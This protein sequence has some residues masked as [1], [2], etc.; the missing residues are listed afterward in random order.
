LPAP[1]FT[2][3]KTLL[4]LFAALAAGFS[5]AR[6]DLTIVE[7]VEG[8]SHTSA[9]TV[10]IKGDKARIE[11]NPQ[12]TTIVDSKKG[13]ITSL[14]NDRKVFL[15]MSGDRLR[16][17]MDM[18][19]KFDEKSPPAAKPKLIPTGRKATINGYETE[20]YGY[21]TP[22]V[23]ASF[24]VAPSY[25]D[26][27]AILKQLAVLSSGPL[28]M[29]NAV[30]PDYA[31]IPGVPLKF[32]VTAG[33]K[34][35]T[36]TVSS[37]NQEPLSDSD[38]DVPSDYHEMKGP[39]LQLRPAG[40]TSPAGPTLEGSGTGVTRASAD[41]YST[42]GGGYSRSVADN[43]PPREFAATGRIKNDSIACLRP[44]YEPR[45]WRAMLRAARHRFS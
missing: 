23:K 27:A 13:E 18:V 22:K 29:Q 31:E 34:D 21:E 28:K 24:W 26:G 42:A 19:N 45:V 40:Q 7:N 30:A 4:S 11:A 43:A 39:Q 17:A 12:L 33:G 44:L 36:T 35:I 38:F 3:V 37:L 41:R 9:M 2:A 25:P 20:E 14:I 5:S 32:V 15:R 1:T 6:A 10:K 8:D 16:A